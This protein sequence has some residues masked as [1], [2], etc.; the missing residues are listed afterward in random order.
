MTIWQTV[1]PDLVGITLGAAAASA[2]TIVVSKALANTWMP[3]LTWQPMTLIGLTAVGLT[4]LA[5]MAPTLW[6]LASPSAR[7]R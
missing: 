7:G 6:I 4:V 2:S 1:I 5:I 3:Y